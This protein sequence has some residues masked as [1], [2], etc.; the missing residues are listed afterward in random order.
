MKRSGLA[1]TVQAYCMN[2]FCGVRHRWC[3]AAWLCSWWH[4]LSLERRNREFARR[5]EELRLHHLP[6]EKYR[7]GLLKAK[8]K[9]G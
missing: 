3:L 2:P 6:E 5:A 1:S 8:H 4:R 9:A 7:E